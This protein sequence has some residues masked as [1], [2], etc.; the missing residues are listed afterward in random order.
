MGNNCGG[1]KDKPHRSDTLKVNGGGVPSG[2]PCD[3]TFKIVIVGD[4][5]VG[6]TSLILRFAEGAFTQRIDSSISFDCKEKLFKI[7]GKVVKL[8]IWDTAGQERF[9]TIS[10][11]YYRGAQGI[12]LAYD[13]T[14]EK[15]FQNTTRQWLL[16]VERYANSSVSKM[17]VGLKNDLPA[18]AVSAADATAKGDELNIKHMEL[19]AMTGNDQDINSP[20]LYI[21]N[22]LLEEQES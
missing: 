15:S 10:S 18:R 5:G 14:D 11:T 8:Q 7:K 16:E 17:L 21:A 4:S 13:I 22:Q 9:R 12:I 3:Y 2:T 20:F 19:S 6:K 1:N